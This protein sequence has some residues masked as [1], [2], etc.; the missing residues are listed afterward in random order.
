M[1]KAITIISIIIGGLVLL[2]A[3]AVMIIEEILK[4]QVTGSVSVIGGADG[5]TSVFVAG[6]VGEGSVIIEIILGVLLIIVGVWGLRKI[7]K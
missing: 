7:K 2:K 5:P 6:T 3:S 4:A 1:K